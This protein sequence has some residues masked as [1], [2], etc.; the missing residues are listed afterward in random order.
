VD[1]LLAI[2]GRCRGGG[3]PLPRR[4]TEREWD[5]KLGIIVG[6]ATVLPPRTLATRSKS[7]IAR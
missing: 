4:T 1:R 3:L 6:V 7:T 5:M 2:C